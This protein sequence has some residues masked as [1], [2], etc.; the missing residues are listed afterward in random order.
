MMSILR[1]FDLKA[2]IY[3]EIDALNYVSKE[4]TVIKE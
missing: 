2:I 4:N 1:Y 3:V